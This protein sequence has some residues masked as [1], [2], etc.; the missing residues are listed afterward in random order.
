VTLRFEA[1]AHAKVTADSRSRFC[2]AQA[3]RKLYTRLRETSQE[4]HVGDIV[5]SPRTKKTLIAVAVIIALVGLGAGFYLYRASRP[6]AGPVAGRSPD[7]FSQI[8][9]D[10][11]LVAYLDAA[12]LR[13]TQNSSL[14]AIGQVVLPT[15]QQDPDYTEFVRNTGFDYTRDLD[16]AAIAMWPAEFGA[17]ANAAGDNPTLAIA[18]GRFDQDRIEAYAIHVGGHAATHGSL[19]IYEVPGNP[20]MSFEFLSATRVAMASGKDSTG[21]L[22]ASSSTSSSPPRDPAMQARIDRVAGA[23]LFA[24]ARTDH[25]PD[26]IYASFKNSA[27]LLTLARSIQAITLAGQPQGDDL[28]VTL[29]A[30][31]DS[32]KNALEIGTLLDG[33]RMIGSVALNDPKERGQM[34]KEQAAFLSTLLAKVKVTPQDKW[35]RLSIALTP[36]MLAGKAAPH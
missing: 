32:M 20:P 12:A 11:P 35:V 36:Q 18:D 9:S 6:L 13:T 17:A 3:R 25:L 1:A 5:P 27:Q 15:P 33:F 22:T 23:P 30:E 29:D 10:A 28:A 31:C 2:D 14:Q 7:V 34:T 8:A 26:S 21:L 4:K 19:T 16:H 24:V